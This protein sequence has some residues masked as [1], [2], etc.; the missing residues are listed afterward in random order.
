MCARAQRSARI[1]T[2]VFFCAGLA[3]PFLLT[4][5]LM[6]W[7]GTFDRFW[8]WTV[9]YARVH[10]SFLGW[11]TGRV[12]LAA[13]NQQAGALRWS[14]V[15]A[16]AGLICLLLDKARKEARFVIGCLLVVSLISF[17]ASFCFFPHYFIMVLPAISLLIALAARRAVAAIGEAIPAGCVAL[18]CIAFIFAHRALWFEQTPEA[19]SHTLCGENPFPEA[20]QI[21]KH[22][23]DHSTAGD[24]I[25]IMGSEPEI[26]FYAHRHSASGYIYMYDLMQ[27]NQ[28]AAAMQREMMQQIEAA[29]PAFLLLVK[30]DLSWNV[31]KES[32]LAIMNWAEAYAGKYYNVAG[33]VWMLPGRTEYVWGREASTR[34]FDTPTRMTLLQRKPGI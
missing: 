19:A 7:A 1:K 15:A 16:A 13:F 21:A 12:D 5:M 14:W 26:F 2:I 17:T 6:A 9:V 22:I 31:A 30:V 4:C 32:D 27:P 11:Q 18:A 10:A 24:T 33:K 8:F 29:K 34:T 23:Q 25:A 28:Y 3:L 20:V